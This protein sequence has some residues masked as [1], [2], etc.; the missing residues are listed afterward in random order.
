[1]IYLSYYVII[2]YVAYDFVMYPLQS[3]NIHTYIGKDTKPMQL[4]TKCY[5]KGY[6]NKRIY[7]IKMN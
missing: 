5:K 2:I 4:Q 1:M 7:T 3:I 6:C